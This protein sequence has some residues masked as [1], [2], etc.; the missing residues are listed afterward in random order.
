MSTEYRKNRKKW[1]YRFFLHGKFWKR[2]AFNTQEEAKNA[3]AEHR[4]DLLKNPPLATDSLGS[5]AAQFLI[6]S[7]ERGR[8]KW[9]ID[10][11]RWNL[12]A[13]IL[14][15]FKP[16]TP[17][18]A[19]REVDV[20]NFIKHHKRRGV[21]NSTIWHYI[22]DL[23]ALFFWAMKKQHRFVRI[24]PVTE[25]DLSLIQNRKVIKSPLKLQNFDRA[26]SVL[27]A[28][29]RAWWRTH[30][31]LGVRMDEGNRLQIAD[32]DFENGLIHIPG[33]KTEQSD[34]YLPMS[35]ALQEELKSYLKTR[36]DD[37]PYLFPGR[38]ARTKGKKIYS[39]RRLF[40]KIKRVTA[41]RAYMEKNPNTA[42]MTAWKELKKQNYPG[43]VKLTTKE[44]RDYF[45]TQ[46]SAQ[47][48]DPNT[49]KILM[50]HT[51]LNTTSR[52]TRTVTDRMKAAVQNL[53]KPLEAS[54]GGN[55]GGKS[56]PKTAE[57]DKLN[58]LRMRLLTARNAKGKSGGGEWSRTTDAADMSRVL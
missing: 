31:C 21:K 2:Y 35:P 24:N 57:N 22:V 50:R 39:R 7:A 17:M 10:A 4:A 42:P 46:V 13:F 27:D 41:F 45:A 8:S 52:Y 49:V 29:E 32:V 15:F 26:F 11:L 36:T 20:E 58:E 54:L 34:C 33:T 23:R 30:E 44:L 3:E 5:V 1:G 56:I 19:I 55:S 51:S 43:G 28:Y 9:R 38:S 14:P 53:G 40:E 16:E 12:N 18:A 37:S 6:D 48:N 47:V 25:A